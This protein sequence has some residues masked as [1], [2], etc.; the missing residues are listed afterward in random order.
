MVGCVL[1]NCRLTLVIRW[2]YG[3]RYLLAPDS[4]AESSKP[5]VSE[6][7]SLL[8]TTSQQGRHYDESSDYFSTS[9]SVTSSMEQPPPNLTSSHSTSREPLTSF[10]ALSVN[11]ADPPSTRFT[12]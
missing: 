5:F 11:S 4:T 8:K 12:S 1:A 6:R 10:P 3:Y 7:S 2:S 9:R